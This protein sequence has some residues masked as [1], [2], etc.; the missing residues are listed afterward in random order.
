MDEL[1]PDRSSDL[2]PRPADRQAL[3]E[4]LLDSALNAWRQG[5]LP[6]L[7]EQRPRAARWMLRQLHPLVRST[8]G[9]RWL[10]SLAG[11]VAWLLG[12][13]VIRLRP[14]RVL[15]LSEIPAEAW[16][17]TPAW[18]PMIAVA[19]H[20][21]LMAIPDL[22]QR[23]RRAADEPAAANLCGLWNVEASTFYRY[24]DR[25]RRN[26]L[27]L[28]HEPLAVDDRLAL[29]RH[30]CGE[31][32]SARG[33]SAPAERQ[34]WHLEQAELARL[35]GQAATAVW[36]ALQAAQAAHD[37]QA[38]PAAP[39]VLS[40]E[41]LLG[42]AA[43]L[44]GEPECDLFLDQWAGCSGSPQGEFNVWLARATVARMRQLPER[45]EQSCRQALLLAERAG[46]GLLRALAFTALGRCYE[47]RDADRAFACYEDA[48]NCLR[49]LEPGF[50]RPEIR[51][52]YANALVRLA[53]MYVRRSQAS[54]RT[55][56]EEVTQLQQQ[57]GLPDDVAGL[58]EQAWAEYW[59]FAGDLERALNARLR[60]LNI[61]ERTGD[62]RSVLST[63][64]NLMVIYAEQKDVDRVEAYAQKIFHA[65]TR[66]AVEP[67]IMVGAHGNL[68]Y[69]YSLVGGYE[70]AAKHY[71]QALAIAVSSRLEQT[72]NIVRHNLANAYFQLFLAR[73][74]PE[75]ERL[76]DEQA[77]LIL[78]ASPVA[79]T[80]SLVERT[81]A[82]KSEVL[83]RQ[84]E[85]SMDRL[86][87]DESSLHLAEMS[88]IRRE[89]LA[90]STQDD[91]AAQAHARLAITRAYLTIAAKEREAAREL[92]ASEGLL[93]QFAAELDALPRAFDRDLTRE[94][95]LGVLWK[96]S[97][98][99]LLDDA[100]RSTLLAHLHR[101]GAVNKSGFAALAGVAPAT[102]SKH[103]VMLAER[104]LLVQRGKGPST[105]YELPD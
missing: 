13:A 29:R 70:T 100:R 96:Q 95:A 8:L 73:G 60:A 53:Y 78:K 23:Y 51:A 85:S 105:R 21:R 55:M 72:A 57:S 40:G 32:F 24:L 18:R 94:Q 39:G 99:D 34:C 6:A 49:A 82:L 28:V 56:L 80:A 47:A 14:D 54:A 42:L 89:R 4:E 19:C 20:M 61:F 103:L 67:A 37:A 58:L 102:A 50:E 69:A 84:P 88:E 25:G 1:A 65:A 46:E 101:E 86:L 10:P 91:A 68:G 104:G 38:G 87:D 15:S 48:L 27:R 90:L 35:K 11:E 7:I 62:A 52:A 17:E 98:A 59:R 92:I 77:E 81:R 2:A 31:L 74:E 79:V 76:G 12:W 71:R 33:W 44:A 63:Y 43:T 66:Q 5:A 3:A 64:R 83:G 16:W 36:H 93:E 41:W 97:A 26:M 9:D 75:Y 45:E 30:L 22:A